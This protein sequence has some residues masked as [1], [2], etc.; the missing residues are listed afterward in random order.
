[1]TALTALA[2]GGAT[3]P[4]RHSAVVEVSPAAIATGE[5][6]GPQDGTFDR[7]T[8]TNLGS[9]NNNGFTSFRTALE[10]RLP[11]LP[12][13][14]IVDSIALKLAIGNSEGSR[15]LQVHGY[16]GDGTV[17]LTDFALD[18]LAATATVQPGGYL[19]LALDV[20]GFLASRGA[21]AG[22]VMGF[23]IRE[24]PPNAANYMIMSIRV[25]PGPPVLSIWYR[26]RQ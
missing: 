10:Y 4:A 18:G 3:E 26:T 9:V 11:A 13:D 20:T 12:S 17:Q 16:E 1:M 2:C 22:R 15:S 8:T 6:F 24:E 7:L 23:N 14:A 21:G 5:D 19:N 25:D